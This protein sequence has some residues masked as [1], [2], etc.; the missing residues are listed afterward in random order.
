[1]ADLVDLAR[2]GDEA[3]FDQ[4]V[5]RYRSELIAHCYRMLG[6]LHD[7]E[8]AVQE[9]L[10]SAWRGLA[11]FEGRS[12]LRTW[13]YRITT[14]ACLRLS[15]NRPH[16]MLS[17]EYG[18]SRRDTADLGELVTAPVF[19][20][21]W[22]DDVPADEP[23]PAASVLRREG[24]ELAFI[25]ALQ[26]LPGTQRAVLILR[27]VLEY[28]AADVAEMLDT[29]T[30]SVNSALQR[31]RRTVQERVP[32]VTQRDEQAALGADGQRALIDAFV[33][34]WERADV[35]AI[36]ALLAEDARFTMPPLPAWFD[37]RE[38]VARF[39]TER[40]FETAWRLVPIRANGQPAFACYQ[41]SPD[42]HRFRLGAINVLSLR[43]GRITEISGFL[44][45]EVHRRFNLPYEF[46]GN[47]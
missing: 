35:E 38:D 46:P 37:G 31:A 27:D 43:D 5:A 9:S 36:V 8:D 45:P 3:A 40:L 12:S 11:G 18:P 15:R 21:P 47:R 14:N 1:V 28:P 25:A 6:S 44:D 41:R 32:A 10:L 24:V 16:R 39:L 17:P 26:H 29:T 22:P 23:D 30:A 34:A 42:D 4:L 20:E 13:L 19:L 7:A 33:A 2:A